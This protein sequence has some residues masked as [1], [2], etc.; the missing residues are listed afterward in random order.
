MCKKQITQNIKQRYR[1]VINPK[2]QALLSQ[3]SLSQSQLLAINPARNSGP[4]S[5]FSLPRFVSI[6][7]PSAN[8]VGSILKIHLE[9]SHFRHHHN[10]LSH[11]MSCPNH[12]NSFQTN[13]HLRPHL[14][15]SFSTQEPELTCSTITQ[16][17]SPLCLKPSK[18]FPSHSESAPKYQHACLLSR[19]SH[20]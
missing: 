14:Q 10:S 9:S 5:L 17:M 20:V 15:W 11:I 16:I 7:K 6:F 4:N 12:C 19:A 13:L 18:G 1:D 2:T 8:S 3:T